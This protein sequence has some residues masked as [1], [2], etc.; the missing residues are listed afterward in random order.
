[1]FAESL[2]TS[3]SAVYFVLMGLVSL[4]GTATLLKLMVVLLKKEPRQGTWTDLNVEDA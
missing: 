1:M 4:V 3:L 2:F